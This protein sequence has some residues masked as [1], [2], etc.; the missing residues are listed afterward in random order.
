MKPMKRR[1]FHCARVWSG[2]PV[3]LRTRAAYRAAA[4]VWAGLKEP[5]LKEEGYIEGQNVLSKIAGRETMTIDCPE[6]VTT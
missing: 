3:F 2:C 4:R 1:E 5:G 6:T